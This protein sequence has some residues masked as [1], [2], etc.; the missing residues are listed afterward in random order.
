MT[1]CVHVYCAGADCAVGE[2]GELWCRGDNVMKGYYGRPEATRH[3]ID[4]HGWFHTGSVHMSPYQQLTSWY[5]IDILSVCLSFMTLVCQ[6]LNF[7]FTENDHVIS[8]FSFSGD[9]ARVDK[10]GFYFIVDRIKELI[11]YKGNQ[12]RT[13]TKRL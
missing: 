2:E 5:F 3:C 8:V 4:E 9:V 6:S 1:S 7:Q 11:K 12:V 13:C 10:D